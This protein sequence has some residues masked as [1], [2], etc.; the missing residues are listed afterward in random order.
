LRRSDGEVVGSSFQNES[1]IV[2]IAAGD[3]HVAA[4]R[5]DGSAVAR[6]FNYFGQCNVPALPNGLRYVEIGAGAAHTAALYEGCPTC[7]PAF[8]LGDGGSRSVPCPCGN[9]GASGRGC[10]NSAPTG[11]ARLSVRGSVDPDRVVLETRREIP[12]AL[13]VFLQGDSV[14]G[15]PIA[16]GDGVR[17]IGG[18]LER[19]AVKTAAGGAASYPELG[20]PSISARSAALGDRIRPGSYRYYQVYYRD[21]NPSFCNPPPATFNVSNAVMVAW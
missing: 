19:I 5:S 9:D 6:G 7:E 8:C 18:T 21:A 1:T 15:T 10:D 2:G 12:G 16:F 20:D 3:E 17:C 14:L 13:S 11:G 4:V